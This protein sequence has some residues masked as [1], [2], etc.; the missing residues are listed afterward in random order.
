M[1]Y[2]TLCDLT[3]Q[4]DGTWYDIDAIRFDYRNNN[5][6][7]D[8]FDTGEVEEYFMPTIVFASMCNGQWEQASNQFK[9][10]G[11]KTGDFIGITTEKELSRL[12]NY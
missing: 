11:L 12:L 5:F 6:N 9:E 8:A 3:D 4:L 1:E 10:Y 2:K 7:L